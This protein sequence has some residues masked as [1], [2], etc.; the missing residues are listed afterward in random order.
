MSLR[1]ELKTA[2]IG[3]RKQIDTQDDLKRAGEYVFELL[4]PIV[5]VINGLKNTLMTG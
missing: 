3:G 5:R 1:L 4:A 2:T